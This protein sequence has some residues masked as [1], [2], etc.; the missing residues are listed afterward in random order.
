MI[1]LNRFHRKQKANQAKRKNP[2]KVY[3]KNSIP[4]AKVCKSGA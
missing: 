4:M 2:K 1:K 3:E